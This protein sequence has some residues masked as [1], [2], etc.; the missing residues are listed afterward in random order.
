[1]IAHMKVLSLC[2]LL[3]LSQHCWSYFMDN[4]KEEYIKVE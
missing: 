2:V 3:Y 1:M 4:Y